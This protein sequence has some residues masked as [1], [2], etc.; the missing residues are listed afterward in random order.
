MLPEFSSIIGDADRLR[1]GNTLIASGAP[2]GAVYEVTREGDL[3]WK[4]E[5]DSSFFY[6]AERIPQLIVRSR[7]QQLSALI[8]AFRFHKTCHADRTHG[9]GRRRR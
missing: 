1:N 9:F 2:R 8:A 7:H 4:L 6:R 3:L 5:S